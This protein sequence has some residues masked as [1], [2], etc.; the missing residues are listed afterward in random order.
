MP[1][2]RIVV[3]G[4]GVAAVREFLIEALPKAQFEQVEENRL[5]KTTL[6]T[7]RY[8]AAVMPPA[9]YAGARLNSTAFEFVQLA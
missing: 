6:R 8:V 9:M 2:P 4:T 5:K 3:A 1:S 7:R